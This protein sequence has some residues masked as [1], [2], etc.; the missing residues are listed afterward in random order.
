MHEASERIA[1]VA[2]ALKV[3]QWSAAA[4]EAWGS[5]NRVGRLQIE[6]A[7]SAAGGWDYQ[8]IRQLRL[9]PLTVS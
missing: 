3:G 1:A 4:E 2:A 6:A 9:V 7:V 5:T 8:S